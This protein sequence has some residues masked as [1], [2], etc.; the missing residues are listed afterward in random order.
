MTIRP[1][2]S[3]RYPR[4][5]PRHARPAPAARRRR[6]AGARRRSVVTLALPELLE[7][8]D[9]TV[10]GLAAALALY[11]AVLAGALLPLERAAAA[12]GLRAVGA[13]GFRLFAVACL[14]CAQAG[15]LTGLLVARGAQALGG[16]AGLVAAFAL[17][18]GVELHGRRL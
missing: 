4:H 15:D 12:L 11:T 8:L 1:A 9:T 6:G 5:C 16:A 2:T 10:E 14:A 13:A 3:L 7:E 18:A 17:L